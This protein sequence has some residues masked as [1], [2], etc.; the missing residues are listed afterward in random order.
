MARGKEMGKNSMREQQCHKAERGKEREQT[1]ARKVHV[2]VD[3]TA[4]RGVEG[5]RPTTHERAEAAQEGASTHVEVFHEDKKWSGC[6]QHSSE[7]SESTGSDTTHRTRTKRGQWPKPRRGE[8]GEELRSRSEDRHGEEAHQHGGRDVAR[9]QVQRTG[10]STE[11]SAPPW[12]ASRRPQDCA[13]ERGQ[14]SSPAPRG[15]EGPRGQPRKAVRPEA[16]YRESE[17]VSAVGRRPQGVERRCKACRSDP[18]RVQNR[19][20]RMR[21]AVPGHSFRPFAP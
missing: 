3:P 15:V 6:S 14:G 17:N 18:G 1:D 13:E 11:E 8:D 7:D 19:R 4:R 16:W 10:Q 21:G 20:Q 5:R 9:G 2:L 12:P